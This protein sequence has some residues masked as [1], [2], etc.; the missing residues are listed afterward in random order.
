[1]FDGDNIGVLSGTYDIYPYL[2]NRQ[3]AGNRYL[4]KKHIFSNYFWKEVIMAKMQ[5][6]PVVV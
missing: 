3:P 5:Q 6:A 4:V 2:Y 1:M